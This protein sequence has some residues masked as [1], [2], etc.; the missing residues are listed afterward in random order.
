M[1]KIRRN[2]HCAL[3]S[4]FVFLNL[5]LIINSAIL[6]S[7]V[8]FDDSTFSITEQQKDEILEFEEEE[9][10]EEYTYEVD[11]LELA[12]AKY[13]SGVNISQFEV[14]EE[15]NGSESVYDYYVG[16]PSNGHEVGLPNQ[17]NISECAI[18]ISTYEKREHLTGNDFDP[19]TGWI[20]NYAIYTPGTGEIVSE[21]KDEAAYAKFEDSKVS[22][23]MF[24]KGDYAVARQHVTV[25]DG[26]KVH[27]GEVLQDAAEETPIDDDFELDPGYGEL[28][29]PY[30]N[31]AKGSGD[32]VTWEHQLSYLITRINPS[33][34]ELLR[35]NPSMAY[36]TT[37][38]IPFDPEYAEISIEWATNN[39]GFEW[40]D[41]YQAR[42]RVNDEY[43]NGI[44]AIDG[45][46]WTLNAT[47]ETLV[48]YSK[49][50]ATTHGSIK[51]TY[52]VT[53]QM[54]KG[55]GQMTLDFGIW[56]MMPD[57]GLDI[58]ETMFDSIRIYANTSTKHK[59]GTLKYDFK[60]EQGINKLTDYKP[61]SEDHFALYAK[62]VGAT[63]EKIQ[64]ISFDDIIDLPESTFYPF[65]YNLT[66]EYQDIL[67]D[68]FI[69]EIGIYCDA[70]TKLS[71]KFE[72]NFWCDN[73][74]LNVSYDHPNSTYS[75]LKMNVD[76]GGGETY[77]RSHPHYV[78]VSN[79]EG[80]ETYNLSFQSTNFS[81]LYMDF[82]I[83]VSY[84]KKQNSANA[85]VADY[86]ILPSQNLV[87]WNVTYNNTITYDSLTSFE[88]SSTI[89][90]DNYSIQIW[91]MP[92]FDN[93]GSN[94]GDWNI[95]EIVDPGFEEIIEIPYGGGGADPGDVG[96]PPSP[97]MIK[98]NRTSK[99][100]QSVRIYNALCNG[101]W[102][103][104]AEQPNY[105][106]GLTFNAS[107]L[108][109]GEILE[110]NIST[111][112]ETSFG[113]FTVNVY[114]ASD[115]LTEGPRFNHNILGNLTDQWT[116][117]DKGLG[118][119]TVECFW[120]DTN[121]EDQTLRIG[122][123]NNTCIFKRKTVAALLQEPP[124]LSAGSIA[125]FR[126]SVNATQPIEFPL[127]GANIRCWENNSG[128]WRL[129]GMDWVGEY[130]LDSLT[131]LGNSNYSLKMKTAGVPQGNFYVRLVI[132]KEYYQTQILTSYINITG[133]SIGV[134]VER[135]ASW[136]DTLLYDTYVIWNNN[137]PYVNDSIN[138]VIQVKLFNNSEPSQLLQDGIVIG[139]LGSNIFY[140]VEVE[141]G[142]YNITLDTTG[143]DISH[144]I[145]NKTLNLTC[146]APGFS[147]N[148]INISVFIDP[149]PTIT[150]I[151]NIGNI[152]ED[153]VIVV[154]G[155]FKNLIDPENP[156]IIIGNLN[157][158]IGNISEDYYSGEME[159]IGEGLF[160]AT[161]SLTGA[162]YLYPGEYH[163]YINGSLTNCQNSTSV[164]KNFTINPKKVTILTVTLPEEVR[165]KAIFKIECELV[166]ANNGSAIIGKQIS[167]NISLETKFGG[168][169]SFL[170]L[171]VTDGTGKANVEYI[172]AD[173]YE[174]G[175]IRINASYAGEYW[176]R[177]SYN[178]LNQEILGKI[179]ST[180]KITVDP[181]N[182]QDPIAVQV[183]Y[184]ATFVVQLNISGIED[185]TNYDIL[186]Y[187]FYDDDT[188][189][190]ILKNLNTDATGKASYTLE[191]IADK[192]YRLRVL[193]EFFETEMISY[194][195]T[196]DTY[197]I[198]QKWNT[199]ITFPDLGYTPRFGQIITISLNF[200]CVEDSTLSYEGL[201]V[202]FTFI[203]GIY[204]SLL[205]KYIEEVNESGQI[206][207]RILFDYT[208]VDTFTG[209]LN[210][211][212]IFI[213]T[214]QIAADSTDKSIS[215]T[216]KLGTTLQI[217]TQVPSQIYTGE[218]Y[219]SVN[220][221][222]SLGNPLVG[223]SILFEI[224]DSSGN[225]IFNTTSVSNSEGI[226]S[227]S[228]R[229]LFTGAEYSIQVRFAEKGIYT[230]SVKVSEDIRVVDTFIVFLDY[231]PYILLVVGI[232]IAALF[233]YQRAYLIPKRRRYRESLRLMYQ[234]MADVENIQYI[235]I[236]TKEGVPLFSKSMSEVPI[237]E[238]LVSGFL[239]AI[240]SF[241]VEI[242]GKMEAGNG[243]FLEELA[244]QQFKI[245]LSEGKFARTALLLLKRP[246][247][248]IK[249]KLKE[250][251]GKFE[252]KFRSELER[253]TG[254]IFEEMTVLSIVEEVFQ[255]DLLYPYRL[256]SHRAEDYQKS[257]KKT[258]VK[259]VT[260]DYIMIE[261]E[262]EPFYLQD[263]ISSLK[264]FGIDETQ[265]FDAVQKL[266][267][268]NICFAINPRTNMLIE[269]FDPIIKEL[270]RD[271]LQVLFALF[272]GN[273][274]DKEINKYL[275]K[276]SVKIT[277]NMND[278]L[279][280]LI[281]HR[282]ISENNEL[283]S[284]GEIIVTL[285]KLIPDL[286]S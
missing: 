209:N 3:F 239:S 201:G 2:R 190:F 75:G 126:I 213:G 53:E 119:Y 26:V 179:G 226:A 125:E 161:I 5:G 259:K 210:I 267:N 103:F 74:Y 258:D 9:I 252:E 79:W 165:I 241:G 223:H 141:D 11:L 25:E 254:R 113:N 186:F 88:E 222:D 36:N 105:L 27:L 269:K 156:E 58:I 265:S 110:Y 251:N 149:I 7:S 176:L 199:T 112:N 205:T 131:Y 208:I 89:E 160:E 227:A 268:E 281:E 118:D 107:E 24:Y 203:Y 84:F 272:E 178:N 30:E 170:V 231:L 230:G 108:Y 177:S 81:A 33:D 282:L 76:G 29:D 109:N 270:N 6:N 162:Q 85:S 99:L 101:S 224:L 139:Q 82:D 48:V 250:F 98:F 49:Y 142:Y 154:R 148:K 68:S 22:S 97:I 284:A 283:T 41:G 104:L 13:D 207:Y 114:N 196:Q 240:S 189:A 34:I 54:R 280:T 70:D 236:L 198:T 204:Q 187:A 12:S 71:W 138:S 122:Y 64:L 169:Y 188:D 83:D 32:T 111:Y 102:G 217:I 55:E 249:G 95:T 261:N 168:V 221:T 273:Q 146:S 19:D 285:L 192:R 67:K 1:F 8:L 80:G 31:S 225:V 124:E 132:T 152:Y 220:I 183:G 115:T 14:Y 197:N 218:Y 28:L 175:E 193:F 72:I 17:W 200:S 238:T 35:G 39:Y 137:T 91:D 51:R 66:S 253:F 257:L 93:E 128:T 167:L 278:C 130:L 10:L 87:Q 233:T 158:I 38:N 21:E 151:Q 234:T 277:K 40:D 60:W 232:F 140:G 144:D 202:S 46:D 171:L 150:T 50:S 59:V 145:Y 263:L 180:L 242:G 120:N 94:S 260:I 271:D 4:L 246:S 174:G 262:N 195:Y 185:L 216:V 44:Y 276:N 245:I 129:W 164:N 157:W 143:L 159:H 96:L 77:I 255:V 163:V 214:T 43:I 211:S 18:N 123:Y 166:F 153:G 215:I 266:K 181:L 86:T 78:D 136:N 37:F 127:T 135:G 219:I 184:N 45:E 52:D 65:E 173:H 206:F 73:I 279:L 229:F 121:S 147:A 63:T 92:A 194:N 69:F 15:G 247:Q 235:L 248:R 61:F 228:L 56:A 116:V 106:D 134:S 172:I 243:G 16:D 237:D 182:D 274:N 23:E 47:S 244:Y 275:S 264:I 57:D 191:G 42:A 62:L 117:V 133:D 20:G 155:S 256:I 90:I 212:V 100:R 286:I